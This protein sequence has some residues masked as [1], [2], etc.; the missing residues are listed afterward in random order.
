MPNPSDLSAEGCNAS[1]SSGAPF[2]CTKLNEKTTTRLENPAVVST[3][4]LFPRHKTGRSNGVN[5][6]PRTNTA[7]PKSQ[8]RSHSRTIA[9][10]KIKHAPVHFQSSQTSTSPMRWPPPQQLPIPA[11]ALEPSPT[12]SPLGTRLPE[13]L[14]EIPHV[15]ARRCI[16]GFRQSGAQIPWGFSANAPAL[17]LNYCKRMELRQ[18]LW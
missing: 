13:A 17:E 11:R 10:Q 8:N 5:S 1:T 3:R 18:L 9:L 6:D 15:P 2:R 12:S 4:S 16:F 14:K 7:D